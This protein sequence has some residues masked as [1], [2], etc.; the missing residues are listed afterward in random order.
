M[1]D[2]FVFCVTLVAV[3][4][5]GS[6]NFSVWVC[7]LA[8]TG[9]PRTVGSGNPGASNVLRLMGKNGALLV[10]FLDV[11]RGFMTAVAAEYILVD[12]R[13]YAVSGV[14]VLGNLWPIFHGFK[15]GKGIATCLGL[16][17][18]LAPWSAALG[19][20]LWLLCVGLTRYSSLGSIFM[21]ASYP[22]TMWAFGLGIWRIGFGCALLILVTFT[23]RNNIR[24]L[25]KGSENKI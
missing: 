20:G 17:L 7:A 24:R 23:H 6:I 18:A 3:Y 5:L 25:W 10:L 4:L 11:G 9:D 12:P 1:M 2:T 15:G 13:C 14:L 8:G 19:V 16:V 22:I 21:L